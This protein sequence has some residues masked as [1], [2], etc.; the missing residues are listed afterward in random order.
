MVGRPPAR[1]QDQG[2]AGPYRGGQNAGLR[3]RRGGRRAWR[4]HS[5]APHSGPPRPPPAPWVGGSTASSASGCKAS[6]SAVTARSSA[7]VTAARTAPNGFAS[8]V[9][10]SLD[11]AEPGPPLLGCGKAV[12]GKPRCTDCKRTRDQAKRVRRPDLHNDAKERERRRRVVADHRA[13][14]GDW[15][16]GWER[17]PAHPS[18]D[19]TADH[20]REV[21]AGGRPDGRL[22]V[23]CRSCNAARSAHL[24]RRV[25]SRMMATDPSPAEQPITDAAGPVVA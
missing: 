1:D 7:R 11:D 10:A 15:C 9:S 3:G 8:G 20:V 19:L 21:A 22:V 25:L 13:M 16:P 12:R 5:G 24:A 18:A 23:R 2:G 4:R 6:A 14:V 17:R